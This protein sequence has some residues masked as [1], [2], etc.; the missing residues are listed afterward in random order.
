MRYYEDIADGETGEYGAYEV[1]REEILEFAGEYDPLPFHTDEEA[2]AASSMAAGLIASGWHVCSIQMRLI[3]DHFLKNAASMGSFGLDFINWKRPVR[4]G[5]VLSCRYQVLSKRVS[6]SRPEMG[7]VKIRWELFDETG[8]VK[9]ETEG[10]QL[11]TVRNPTGA[12]A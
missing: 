8:Q 9:A 7:I 1:T 11:F 4:P 2:A 10:S 3:Y 6:K 5:D 12:Q